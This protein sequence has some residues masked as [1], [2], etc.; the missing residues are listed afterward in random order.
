MTLHGT[1]SAPVQDKLGRRCGPRYHHLQ[2]EFAR[3]PVEIR[4]TATFFGDSAMSA[5]STAGAFGLCP[6]RAELPRLLKQANSPE[7][8]VANEA[9]RAIFAFLW[10]T[11]LSFIQQHARK[12]WGNGIS[13]Q[14]LAMIVIAEML[15]EIDR[16][17]DIDH[18]C[19]SFRLRIVGRAIDGQRRRV[20]QRQA[21]ESW[22]Y[23]RAKVDPKSHTDE[24]IRLD[25][26]KEMMQ[27]LRAHN[28]DWAAVIELR[29]LA[30]N[31][32]DTTFAAI[33]RALGVTDSTAHE[34]FKNAM[35]WLQQRF[36]E[37]RML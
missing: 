27:A 14:S 21:A 12:D 28:R 16:F 26:V 2:R 4:Q 25:M 31:V 17:T 11:H 7:T 23:S 13:T 30:T 18:L 15:G 19:N 9:R 6:D 35:E 20:L 1:L 8:A 24:L 36:P 5:D 34:W 33:G 37:H 3:R 22:S 10:D 32:Q 29:Y